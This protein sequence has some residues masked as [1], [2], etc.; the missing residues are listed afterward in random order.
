[1]KLQTINSLLLFFGREKTG[2]EKVFLSC[3]MGRMEGHKK[4][5]Y[6]KRMIIFELRQERMEKKGKTN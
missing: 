1:M 6:C 4:G 5:S 2:E 3:F